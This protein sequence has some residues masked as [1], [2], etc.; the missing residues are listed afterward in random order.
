MFKLETGYMQHRWC[1]ANKHRSGDSTAT[2]N[3][4]NQH[5]SVGPSLFS[6]VVEASAEG[7][8]GSSA[9]KGLGLLNQGVGF[10]LKE[11]EG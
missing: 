5:L 10:G 2:S 6:K 11:V 8:K 7:F 9:S 3:K 1:W 4:I